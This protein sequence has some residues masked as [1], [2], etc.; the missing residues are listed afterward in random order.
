LVRCAL[1]NGLDVAELRRAKPLLKLQQRTASF[2]F[3][4]TTHRDGGS[5]LLAMKGDPK[6]ILAR[7]QDAI[8]AEGTPRPLTPARRSAI[9]E[10]KE[11]M[12]GRGLRVLGFAQGH[13]AA[14]AAG[15]CAA[16]SD[17]VWLGV[18]ALRDP[19]RPDARELLHRLRR[20]GIRTMMLT[21]DQ[22]RTAR[23]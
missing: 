8:D 12:A 4:L 2:R 6:E 13:A 7:C 9:D 21:G 19:I 18:A 1:E 10:R 23:A 20:V 5:L 16:A 3:M 22:C 14:G 11:A 17:M 15:E